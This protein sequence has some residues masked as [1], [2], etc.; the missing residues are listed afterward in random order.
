M[1]LNQLPRALSSQSLNISKHGDGKPHLAQA[2]LL[3]CPHGEKRFPCLQS[4]PLLFQLKKLSLILPSCTPIGSA[5]LG[6]AA[7]RTPETLSAPDS[8][9]SCPSVPPHR[10]VHS[11]S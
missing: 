1:A 9:S 6:K 3:G 2:A 10:H 4:K 11:S 5:F 8:T 7:V